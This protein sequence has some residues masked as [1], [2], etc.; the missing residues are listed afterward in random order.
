MNEITPEVKIEGVSV[1][2]LEGQYQSTGGLTAA[3]LQFKLPLSYAG[4]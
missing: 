3:T 1:D 2:Y 4:Y